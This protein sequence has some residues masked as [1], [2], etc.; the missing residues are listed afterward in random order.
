MRHLTFGTNPTNQFDVAILIKPSSF[1]ETELIGNYVDT[2]AASGIPREKIIA[3][4]LDYDDKGKASATLCKKYLQ[5][6]LPALASLSVKYLYCADASYFKVLAKQ[7]KADAN[8]GYMHSVA[9]KDYEYMQ[10]T[11]G[12]NYSALVYN[13]SQYP[14]LDLS[15]DTLCN[16][17]K[18]TYTELGVDIIHFEDYPDTV[19]KVEWELNR[20]HQFPKLACDTET[21]SLEFL[22]AGLGTIAFAWNKHEGCA[23]AVECA[24][25]PG[26]GVY[27]N[28]REPNSLYAKSV[29]KL[30]KRFFEAY[31]GKL[32]FHNAAYDLKVL[33]Y[34]LWMKDPLDHVGMLHG[35]EILSRH[36]DDTKLIAYLAVNSTA[37]NELGLKVL[38]H[39]FAGNWAQDNVNDIRKIPMAELLRYNLV[40]CL[41]TLFVHEKYYP[42]MVHDKQ[43]KLYKEMFLPTLKV[44]IQMELH[45]MPIEAAQV[46]IL[47]K[48]LIADQDRALSVLANSN[49]V[50]IA[51][52]RVQLNEL[53][54]INAKLKEKRHGVDKV[55]RYKFNPNSPHHLAV[56]LHEVMMLP[57]LERT[58]S[59]QP[60][61]GGD[62]LEKLLNH[63][64]DP[65]KL[66]VLQALFDLAK[67]SKIIS[68]FVPAFK[69]AMPKADG[70][71]YLHGNFNL[72]G[73]VSGRL[74]S[75][76]P[77]LQ[78]IPSGSIYGKPVKKCFK[79]PKGKLFCGAD[80]HSLED[81]ISALTTKD[82]NKLK[83][84]LDGYC[85]HCLRAYFYFGEE[86][87]PDLVAAYNATEDA[88]ERV[89]IVNS[90]K[91]IYPQWRQKSK[92]PTF[93][94]TY[95]GTWS[96]LVKNCGFS[97]MVAKQIEASY[98]AM[99][100]VS[101]NWVK[102]KLKEACKTGYVEVAFGLRVRTPLL[103]QSV[104]GNSKTMREAE[105]EGR[106]AGNALGQSYGQLNNRA[107]VEFMDRVWASPYKYDIMPVAL[108]HDAIYL[109]ITDCI[110]VVKWANDN[111]IDCMRWQELPEIQHDQVKIGAEL[112][113]FHPNWSNEITLPN[114]KTEDE[115]LDICRTGHK[116]YYEHYGAA[117]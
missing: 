86:H 33:I 64:D 103:A 73:T 48:E 98:H 96:T 32:V 101:D 100:E 39:S 11:V 20:L 62:I 111:L 5:V 49:L 1:N 50:S 106:T 80:F 74:S 79:P 13:P 41:S 37:G 108:I 77:N 115:L 19:R 99:Y 76:G 93:A 24:E 25:D 84:Y 46:N 90:M 2:M 38:A 40:D 61:T 14:K 113:I 3:F 18:G 83:V 44:I 21:F 8:F 95:Q 28:K 23:F 45:G 72:G 109:V 56:L 70:L 102:A 89:K 52:K 34:T 87:M 35:L 42:M 17:Y 107:I 58:P 31:K 15:V 117:A 6:L 67:V 29:K 7:A 71:S 97:P 27:H 82:P 54:K 12:L 110:E 55:A 69:N 112:G 43:E 116:K 36:L 114:Y 22:K 63:T 60:A 4:T 16:A 75:S 78:Q 68:A 105:A 94:L 53:I 91:K 81:Y 92:A 9:I 30:L 59:K 51:E 85:G 10:I 104:L 88:A 47:E 66:E 57:V 65:E 26:D